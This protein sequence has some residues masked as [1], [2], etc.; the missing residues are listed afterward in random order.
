[1]ASVAI[2]VNGSALHEH[3]AESE[4]PRTVTSYVDTVS[5]AEF[6]IMLNL[7]PHYT[8]REKA[9]VCAISLDGQEVTRHLFRSD[10]CRRGFTHCI[11]N[12]LDN[13]DGVRCFK[14]FTFAQ[15]V[16]SKYFTRP[17]HDGLHVANLA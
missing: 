1:M 5:G 17:M 6:S 2:H 4:Q 16:S 14:K 13:V 9:L 12:A 10:A 7:G 3:T 8:P 15:H 11:D